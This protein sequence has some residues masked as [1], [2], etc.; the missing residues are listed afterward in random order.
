MTNVTPFPGDRRNASAPRFKLIPFD[1]IQTSPK[2]RYVVKGLIPQ[3]GLTV[4]WGPPKCGKSFWATD[5]GLHIALDWDYRGHRVRGGPVV[6][7]A[8]EGASGYGPRLD[9]FRARHLADRHRDVPFYL[10]ASPMKLVQDQPALVDAI[11]NE[12]R[13]E[14]PAVV[15]IDTLNRS[16]GG[17]E[18]DDRDMAAY[19]AAADA[20]RDALGCA[21]VI[22][23]HCGLDTTRPRGH[24]SLTGAADAQLAAKRDAA[25]NITVTVEWMK[26]GP[27]G[28]MI[29][30]RLEP[31]AVGFDADG[32][33]IT[34]CVVVAVD[35][36]FRKQSSGRSL[37]DRQRLAL[38]AL[39]DAAIDRGTPPPASFGLPPG[40]TVV[41]TDDWRSKIYARGD[42][43]RE[44][45]NPRE[46]FRRLRNSLAARGLIGERDGLVWRAAA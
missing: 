45:K 10:V 38:E 13:G 29:A 30:S 28:E 12:L 18:S 4:L 26:D 22:V 6:Y 31:V 44:A 32:D 19:V 25:D 7:C 40:L 17:S 5:L 20:I 14:N 27:E 35:G 36:P 9:A 3:A 33:P 43:D 46:D 15:F 11:W 24:T 34:S 1:E 39:A 16:I 21:V 41:R 23:H 2:P 37:S 8:L 42:L